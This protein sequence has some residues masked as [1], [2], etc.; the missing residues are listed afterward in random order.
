MITRSVY[1]E[2]VK[3]ITNDHYGQKLEGTIIESSKVMLA[4]SEYHMRRG[5]RVHIPII[6]VC[7]PECVWN[8]T[9]QFNTYEKS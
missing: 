3:Y 7:Q 5:A 8:S 4:R 2:Y 6:C 1:T 9:K